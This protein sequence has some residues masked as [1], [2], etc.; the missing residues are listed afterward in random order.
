MR[1]KLNTREKYLE[2]IEFDSNCILRDINNFEKEGNLWNEE[3]IYNHFARMFMY[4]HQVLL[5]KYSMGEP[6]T[7]LKEDYSQ[8][9]SFMEKGWKGISGYVQMVW[10]LSIG[11]MLEVEA[12]EFN[13]LV[14]LAE[15]DNLRDYLTDFLIQYRSASWGKQHAE[16]RFPKPYQ[17]LAEVISL[18][19][20]DKQK[21]VERLQKY[22]QKEWYKGH[23][24]AGWYDDHKSKWGVHFGYWSF[25]SG[26]LV[27]ILGL[28]DSI[29]KDQQY[30]PYDMVHW[31]D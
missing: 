30:Y 12:E 7:N 10:M 15:R 6:V 29:L 11:I 5:S 26:A 22:L 4:S 9:V 24:G 23:S 2:N 18:A 13:K 19:Q 14:Q 21:A 8:A 3:R 20:N 28:N 31:K 25:E 17:T 1:D 16:F 27:K